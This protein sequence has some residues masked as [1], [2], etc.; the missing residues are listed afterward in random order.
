MKD[1]ELPTPATKESLDKLTPEQIADLMLE[2]VGRVIKDQSQA[3]A[4]SIWATGVERHLRNRQFS[5]YKAEASEH[6]YDISVS[7]TT[8][9]RVEEWYWQ[10]FI[11]SLE[12]DLHSAKEKLAGTRVT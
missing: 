10:E 9:G 12:S 11:Q 1:T 3:E 6:L 8:T 5:G 7:L 4:V 2:M